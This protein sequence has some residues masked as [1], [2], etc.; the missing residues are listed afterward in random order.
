MPV[1][2]SRLLKG[3]K[4]NTCGTMGAA[5]GT[6]LSAVQPPTIAH[7]IHQGQKRHSHPFF[8]GHSGGPC[9]STI[10]S[11]GWW[12]TE[13]TEIHVCKTNNKKKPHQIN[14]EAPIA[15]IM[16][17]AKLFAS[18]DLINQTIKMNSLHVEP[19]NRIKTSLHIKDAQLDCC[20]LYSQLVHKPH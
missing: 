6:G 1:W 3:P 17:K 7:L 14:P 9:V 2:W 16:N 5:G 8:L 20:F 12:E 4:R 19:W 15:W 13:D 10:I 18:R 11:S